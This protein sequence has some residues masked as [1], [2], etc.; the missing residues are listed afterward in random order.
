VK[1]IILGMPKAPRRTYTIL[2]LQTFK[3]CFFSNIQFSHKLGEYVSLVFRISCIL[4]MLPRP[5]SIKLL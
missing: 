4:V 1:P 2:G 3:H 5:R